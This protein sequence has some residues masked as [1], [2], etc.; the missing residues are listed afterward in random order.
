MR[1]RLRTNVPTALVALS[2]TLGACS[3]GTAASPSTGG[4]TAAP[5]GDLSSLQQLIDQYKAV[6]SFVP[7]GPPIDAAKV[8]GKTVLNIP[9]SS[10]NPFATAAAEAEAEAAARLGINYIN[11]TN[12]GQLTQWVT[13]F[14]QAIQRKVDVINDWG[15]ADPR[16]LA[17]QIAAAQ[18]AGIEVIGNNNSGFSQAV[19]GGLKYEVPFPYELAGELMASWVVLD[20]KRNANALVIVSNEVAASAAILSNIETVFAKECPGCKLT[21]VNVPVKDWSTQIQTNVQSAMVRD[22]ELNY[23]IPIYDSMTQFV[24]PAITAAN[25]T[26][27]VFVSTFNGTP[28]VLKYL[29]EGDIVRMNVGIPV[30]QVGWAFIDADARLLAGMKLPEIFDAKLPLRVFTKDNVGE[31]GT[32]P[33]LGKGYNATFK[34]DYEKLWGL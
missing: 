25:Q 7:P 26:G 3:G 2:L 5:S 15:G 14:D 20:T 6:P 11:C 27:K 21:T 18:A 30:D 10:G 16:A 12:Q 33:V 32:P 31:T 29:Q 1:M 23:V 28:F 13:C 17:P 34:S 4:G 19:P 24:V 22:P 9:D 8:K